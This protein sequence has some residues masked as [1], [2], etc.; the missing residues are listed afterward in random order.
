MP[1]PH[2][3][4]CGTWSAQYPATG[5]GWV[6]HG[7]RER[8]RSASYA[9]TQTL[10]LRGCCLL[11]LRHAEDRRVDQV[12]VNSQ[13]GAGDARAVDAHCLPHSRR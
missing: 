1:A 13:A 6:L 9:L 7:V 11:P 3:E 5:D 4:Q 12:V 2:R 10:N 8:S